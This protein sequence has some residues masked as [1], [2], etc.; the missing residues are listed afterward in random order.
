MM[1][2]G[3]SVNIEIGFLTNTRK[4]TMP[5]QAKAN[6]R[7]AFIQTSVLGPG[8][9]NTRYVRYAAAMIV[10]ACTGHVVSLYVATWFQKVAVSI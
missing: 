2:N 4:N 7:N 6:A 9:A 5:F 8:L 3:T 1:N 10:K